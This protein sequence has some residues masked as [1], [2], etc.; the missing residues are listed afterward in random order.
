MYFVYFLKSIPFPEKTY[1]GCSQDVNARLKE[2][3]SGNF[4]HT[5]K[6]MPWELV[7]SIGFKDKSKAVAFEQYLKSGS[8]NAFAFKRFW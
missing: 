2:H 7:V 5:S 4:F 6:Y 3:N 1:I 8:G